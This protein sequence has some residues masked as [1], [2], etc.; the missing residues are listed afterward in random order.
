MSHRD[1]TRREFLRTTAGSLAGL[2]GGLAFLSHLPRVSAEDAAVNPDLVRYHDRIE[3]LV[4]LIEETPRETLLERVAEQI[5]GGRSYGEVLASLLL[6]GVRNVQPR[7]SVGFKFHCVL[8]VNSCH[9]ASLAGPDEDRWLPLFW[10]LDYFKSSQADEAKSTGWRMK[11]VHE[12][13]VPDAAHARAMFTE[14]MESWDEDKA[15]AAA[16]GLV[17]TAGATDVFN[18]FA[19]YAARDFRSIG[20]KAIYLANSW[21]TLQVIGWEF[22]EPVLR[23]LAFALL[24]HSEEANPAESDLAADRPWRENEAKIDRIPADWIGGAVDSAATTQL[25]DAFRNAGPAD[26]AET[27]AEAMSRGIGA[28]SIWDGVF[29]GAGELL[30]RQPGI[31]GLHG[32]TTANAMHYLW[33][34]AAD[35]R[36]RKRLLLQACSFNTMFR[37]AALG[38]GSLNDQTITAL[39]PATL[40]SSGAA[41]VDEI[42]AAISSDRLQAAA[43]V[44]GYLSTG[45]DADALIDAARRV[46]FLKG[47]N[48]HDYKF[49]EAV[50]EDYRH[51]SPEYRDRFM[52]AA[53]FNLRG[54]GDRDSGLVQRTRAAFV[55]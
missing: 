53:V 6:A 52:A 42:L 45:G 43:K 16:A 31:I 41:A 14:A 40:Q 4:R 2:S 17:R 35:D 47:D 29:V 37:E 13:L 15:D 51:V 11:P 44:Y 18:L 12:S 46:L 55:G 5:R 21:R 19:E 33:K 36:L 48:A 25:F 22:A 27:V 32:L 54:S 9:L 3:P 49:S 50:L 20:H 8:V 10:G 39:K 38:R 7:P 1:S 26:A 30:M 23:S 34:N 24:N 28:Q